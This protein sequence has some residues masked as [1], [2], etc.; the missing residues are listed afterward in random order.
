MNNQPKKKLV[1]KKETIRV[2]LAAPDVRRFEQ[3]AA[4]TFCTCRGTTR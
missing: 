1:I 2:A 3:P 4:G